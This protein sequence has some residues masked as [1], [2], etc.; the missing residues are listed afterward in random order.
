M[1]PGQS[2][3]RGVRKLSDRA[4]RMTVKFTDKIGLKSILKSDEDHRNDDFGRPSR[5]PDSLRKLYIFE[6]TKVQVFFIKFFKSLVR[7]N[8][9]QLS[10]TNSNL[11]S[12]Q[13]MGFDSLP[14]QEGSK[15]SLFPINYRPE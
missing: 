15:K 3:I 7:S 1:Y 2:L 11:Y 6:D 12:V 8:L 4:R 10:S 5:E 14:T 9:A 13:R